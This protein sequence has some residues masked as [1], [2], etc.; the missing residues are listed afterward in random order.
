MRNEEYYN[1]YEYEVERKSAHIERVLCIII[2]Q[3]KRKP[4]INVIAE[5]AR[6][7]FD[8][9]NRYRFIRI[10][11]ASDFLFISITPSFY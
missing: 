7:L 3:N 6:C 11:L 4:E 10:V 9:S 2:G 1:R 8:I 5:E